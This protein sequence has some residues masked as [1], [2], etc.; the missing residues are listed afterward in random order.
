MCV[1]TNF[2]GLFKFCHFLSCILMQFFIEGATIMR[3]TSTMVPLRSGRPASELKRH[4][5]RIEK[6]LC[7]PMNLQQVSKC[8]CCFC[9]WHGFYGQIHGDEISHQAVIVND[10]F[11]LF[12]R[13][14]RGIIDQQHPIE[15]D[16]ERFVLFRQCGSIRLSS[17]CDGARRSI[18]SIR[19][20]RYVT[21]SSS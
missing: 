13:Q 5:D 9:I 8:D 1:Y 10:V 7:K 16:R 11:N 4:V 6:L 17:A 19:R 2:W 20:S 14:S 12:V 15:S 21:F 18:L 3:I